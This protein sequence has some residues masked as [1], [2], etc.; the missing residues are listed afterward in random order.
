MSA[1]CLFVQS[2]GR[3]PEIA[4]MVILFDYFHSILCVYSLS[5]LISQREGYT[6]QPAFYR[7]H[8]TLYDAS[9][10]V[11]RGDTYEG[12]LHTPI[13]EDTDIYRCPMQDLFYFVVDTSHTV[14]LIAELV[15]VSLFSFIRDK[16][17]DIS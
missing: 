6:E 16:L 5:I 13:I 17:R 12:P 15:L 1:Y 8:L 2:V 14:F 11:F 10:N 3:I 7:F 4:L 9:N